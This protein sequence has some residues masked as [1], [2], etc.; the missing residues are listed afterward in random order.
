MFQMWLCGKDEYCAFFLFISVVFIYGTYKDSG[1]INHFVQFLP[2][3]S[4]LTVLFT[5]HVVSTQGAALNEF[6]LTI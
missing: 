3:F 4:D 2:Y 5:E 1:V 6:L